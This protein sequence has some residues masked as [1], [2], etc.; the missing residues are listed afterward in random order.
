MHSQEALGLFEKI[1]DMILGVRLVSKQDALEKFQSAID[2]CD[3]DEDGYLSIRE[4]VRLFKK[5]I[6]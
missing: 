3:A 4:L 2:E 6:A 5:A 1:V